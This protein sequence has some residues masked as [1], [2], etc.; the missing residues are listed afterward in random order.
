[1][2]TVSTI[3]FDEERKGNGEETLQ[4]INGSMTLRGVHSLNVPLHLKTHR[5]YW[6]GVKCSF[7]EFI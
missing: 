6:F 2:H 5:M 4:N 1:M 7:H 3:E